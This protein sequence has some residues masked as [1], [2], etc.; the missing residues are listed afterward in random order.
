MS[1]RPSA[2]PAGAV[3]SPPSH[4]APRPDRRAAPRCLPN[5]WANRPHQWG[6]LTLATG[7]TAAL[8]APAGPAGAA[9]E[10]STR[11]YDAV[12][13]DTLR[14]DA[15]RTD[16][17]A[18]GGTHARADTRAD[19]P[20]EGVA[21]ATSPSDASSS[22]PR[23]TV[24]A[25]LQVQVSEVSPAVATPGQ[26]VAVR[27]AVTNTAATPTT[28]PVEITLRLGSP[29]SVLTRTQ[30][31]AFADKPST[32]GR[33]VARATSTAPVPAKGTTA[34]NVTIPG[35]A[36]SSSRPFGVLPVTLQEQVVAAPPAPTPT[37]TATRGATPTPT[38]SR[39]AS[40]R[41]SSVPGAPVVQTHG[42]FLPFQTRKEYQPL[43]VAVVAPLTLDPDPE[44]VNA[45]GTERKAAWD[46]AVGPG[47]RI[48]RILDT[49][50]DEAVTWAVD[51]AILGPEAESETRADADDEPPGPT[52]PATGT[53]S[54]PA[55]TSMPPGMPTSTPTASS[56]GTPT[57][58]PP[59]TPP[60]PTATP[61][62]PPTAPAPPA[63]PS[64]AP[65]APTTTP[66]PGATP[67]APPVDTAAPVQA[68]LRR[69]LA[70][71]AQTHPVWA[72]PREDPDL[73][74]LVAAGASPD[75]LTRYLGEDDGLAQ[76]L[77][78]AGVARV[79][80]PVGTPL[81]RS[82][83]QE[84]QSAFGAGG[85]TAQLVPARSLDTD[86]DV[87][88]G[89]VRRTASGRLVLAADD[90]LSRLLTSATDGQSAGDVT[91]RALAETV[92]LLA[93]S[94]GRRRA[95]LLAAD[96][97]FDPDPTALSSLLAGLRSAP[98]IQRVGTGELLDPRTSSTTADLSEIPRADPSGAQPPASPLTSTALERTQSAYADV[99][100]L[101]SVLSATPTSAIVPD[102]GTLD[103]L[104]S[105]RWRGRTSAWQELFTD[106]SQRLH[107]LTTGV[108]VVPST[109]NFF[110]EHG[111]MQVTVVNQLDVEVHDIH[112]VLDPQG[113][114]PRL[115]VTKEPPP[116]TI[117]PGSR[118]TVR[119]QVEAIAAG[120]VPVSAHL[121]TPENTRLGTD[122]TVRVRVQP[123]NGWVMLALGG[124]AGVV[125]LAGLYRALR[126]G[127]PRLSSEDLKEIDRE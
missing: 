98:W 78:V 13:T 84:V 5:R 9:P 59:A 126:A 17:R 53:P 28:G 32:T 2:D 62:T 74:A 121:A 119:V 41:T 69:R 114:P 43:D 116:L 11:A 18:T 21:Q 71:L 115:R 87:T 22:A 68:S 4:P 61:S 95:V 23:E 123:T 110:A 101:T 51:P 27:V 16:A 20:A 19:V 50:Q 33:L 105:S 37:T 46:R 97:G 1:G 55:P 6:R 10:T 31:R 30:V 86:P 8:L 40:G 14:T 56:A 79:A 90:E 125:F 111:I 94:P 124:L 73:S 26:P 104:V 44:L 70:L 48:E 24:A 35:P 25:P 42:T 109:I 88:G 100:G 60:A 45:T 7:L 72:L 96:R 107:T 122:A 57:A 47:S 112:L 93:E 103:A 81:S 38:P 120:V 99:R 117:R 85:P 76:A 34:V 106:V 83:M 66:T 77:E 75:T 12:R 113:R 118:T 91:Q 54:T 67:P 108:T 102:S 92:A 3:S 65:A 39:T 58:T 127:R 64:T 63:T 89:A 29:G 36:I 82:A 15:V 52:A 49:T 80:W